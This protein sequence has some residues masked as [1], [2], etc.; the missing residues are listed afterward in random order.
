MD[1]STEILKWRGLE[2]EVRHNPDWCGVYTAI[3]GYA[4]AHIEVRSLN[5]R[6]LP[7]SKTGYQSKFDRADNVAAEGGAALYV[8]AW[9]DH[10][11]QS[12]RNPASDP[13]PRQLSFF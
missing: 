5:G 4:L 11:A 6:P 10:A 3:Y 9:I 12:Q 13:D 2:I 1:Y 7:I 8:R